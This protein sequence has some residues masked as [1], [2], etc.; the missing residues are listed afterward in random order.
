MN[1]LAPYLRRLGYDT[2]PPATSETL[3]ELHRRHLARIPYDNLSIQLGRPDTVDA[4]D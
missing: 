2:P 4:A 3:V 1:E